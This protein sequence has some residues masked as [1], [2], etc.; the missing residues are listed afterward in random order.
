MRFITY[1][2]PRVGRL[3]TDALKG[4]WRSQARLGAPG[5]L[6]SVRYLHDTYVVTMYH[7]FFFCCYVDPG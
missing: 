3:M 6:S 2:A 4:L 7:E 5:D 1:K